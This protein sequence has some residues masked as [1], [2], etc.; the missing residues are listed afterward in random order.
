MKKWCALLLAIVAVFSV[1]LTAAAAVPQASEM[2]NYIG[3]AGMNVT[4]ADD[5]IHVKMNGEEGATFTTAWCYNPEQSLDGMTITLK[6]LKLDAANESGLCI[7]FG[8]YEGAYYGDR[9]LMFV[10]NS[11]KDDGAWVFCGHGNPADG[12]VIPMSGTGAFGFSKG[13]DVTFK[14]EKKDDATW[15]W[16]ISIPGG[17]KEFEFKDSDVKKSIDDEEFVFVSFGGWNAVANVEYTITSVGPEG[18][19]DG[20]SDVSTTPSTDDNTGTQPTDGN[21]D[22]GNNLPTIMIVIIVV[23]AVLLLVTI[24]VL[25]YTFVVIKSKKSD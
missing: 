12:E 6:D 20:Q 23:L 2:E 22:N 5:G 17:E 9:T 4:Q 1:T 3:N 24:G 10:L 14:W 11:S 21:V 8:N 18:A 16:R 25:V 7:A 15:V 19:F 13:I